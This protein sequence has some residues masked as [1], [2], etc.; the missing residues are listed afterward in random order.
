MGAKKRSNA[1]HTGGIVIECY[2]KYMIL[3]SHGVSS[4]ETSQISNPGHDL[5][6]AIKRIRKV[7]AHFSRNQTVMHWLDSKIH[8][9]GL[10]EVFTASRKQI[11]Y[12]P[13][14][15]IRRD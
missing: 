15:S 1:M 12:K 5:L 3:K 10:G 2:L 8:P 4:F 6:G 14:L 11:L 9:P 7:Y 13:M